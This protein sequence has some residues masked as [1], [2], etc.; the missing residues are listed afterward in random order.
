MSKAPTLAVTVG[1]PA[2]IGPE[3]CAMLAA[4][5][6][7]AP[8]RA[9]IVLVGDRDLLV[10]RAQRIGLASPADAFSVVLRGPSFHA[11]DNGCPPVV[12]L[13]LIFRV[14]PLAET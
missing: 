6:A 9:R 11:S 14:D 8:L 7:T 3:L 10:A 2:G 4:H 5:H 13:R 12:P 1:E